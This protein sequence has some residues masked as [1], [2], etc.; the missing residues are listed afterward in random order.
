MK[1]MG[2]ITLEGYTLDGLEGLEGYE[3]FKGCNTFLSGELLATDI[4]LNGWFK[5]LKKSVKKSVKKIGRKIKK[6]IKKIT[7]KISK[8]AKSTPAYTAVKII[9]KTISKNPLIKQA[10]QTAAIVAGGPVAGIALK[11]SSDIISGKKINFTQ[12]ASK[13][14]LDVAVNAIAPYAPI[15]AIKANEFFSK[16]REIKKQYNAIKKQVSNVQKVPVK[17]IDAEK[18]QKLIEK[19]AKQLYELNSI[20]DEEVKNGINEAN[21]AKEIYEDKIVKQYATKQQD[22]P[23]LKD[24]F[25][26][27]SDIS[28]K[29]YIEQIKE[30]FKIRPIYVD[31]GV[32][33]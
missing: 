18:K 23:Y 5:K 6:P 16:A 3:Q 25:N 20:F 21:K 12:L 11:M 8:I 15:Q 9:N 4:Y 27:V 17:I 19:Y 10:I 13:G 24:T 14:G 28:N 7:K 29:A 30:D 32:I 26:K 2:L 22:I 31:T 1:N 33:Q